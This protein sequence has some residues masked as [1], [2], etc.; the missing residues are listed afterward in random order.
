MRT[1]AIPI[2]IHLALDH[3][4]DAILNAQVIGEW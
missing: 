4:Y 3:I 1:T 2:P